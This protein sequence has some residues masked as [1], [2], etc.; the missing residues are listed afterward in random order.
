MGRK[1]GYGIL[2]NS[3]ALRPGRVGVP[4]NAPGT[5]GSSLVKDYRDQLNVG[6]IKRK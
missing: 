6:R 4:I 1:L 3:L 2:G 5:G